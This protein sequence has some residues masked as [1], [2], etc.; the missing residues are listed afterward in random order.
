MTA[1][2][3]MPTQQ[4]AETAPSDGL[5]ESQ[6]SPL[7][8][9][10]WIDPELDRWQWL[11][12]WFLAI[13][14]LVVLALL[15]VA[16]AVLTVVA[17]VAIVFTGTY[18]RSIFEF[19]VGVLRW[20][21]RVV[22]YAFDVLATDR[23]PPFSLEPDPT[24][25]ADLSVEYP[26]SLSRGLVLVK[27]WLLALPQLLIAV[28]FTGIPFWIPVD[29]PWSMA[30][31]GLLGLLTLAAMVVLLFSGRYPRSLF[32]LIMGL[33]RWVYRVL[34]Y[35]LLMTDEYPPFRL[36]TGSTEP[37]FAPAPR[38]DN[39]LTVGR[40]HAAMKSRTPSEELRSSIRFIIAGVLVAAA[41]FTLWWLVVTTNSEGDPGDPELL[42]IFAAIPLGIGIYRVLHGRS[43]MHPHR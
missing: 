41:A 30:A 33:N 4:S 28:V 39:D 22:Y 23:Y 10:G 37:G 20:T 17:G 42:P 12:K 8:L 34:A 16:A 32:D 35:V 29:M 9:E 1:T 6:V 25:P 7:R 13:P 43:R 19:N 27:S 24:Y 5:A 38:A 18:P 14:H 15:W 26:R 21:W 2:D 11:W 3:K 31:G 40:T 36:D